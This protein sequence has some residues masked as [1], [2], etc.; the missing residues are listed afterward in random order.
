VLY[1]GM[2]LLG[3]LAS[4]ALRY[5]PQTPG[6]ETARAA[7]A[8]V[9]YLLFSAGVIA[10]IWSRIRAPRSRRW[11]TLGWRLAKLPR[12]IFE[13]IGGYGVLL[14]VL[15]VTGFGRSAILSALS[16]A[17]SG[18]G[19]V[20]NVHA[21]P[22][23]VL[24]FLLICVVA[25]VVEEM[26]FRGF[27]YAGLRRRMSVFGAVIASALLF[28]LMHNNPEALLPI[29]LIGIVLAALYE[30]NR[31]IVPSIICHALNNTLVFFLMLLAQ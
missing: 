15:A 6:A 19:L 21:T 3:M 23:K 2:A 17:Q 25:P 31:S 24:L 27:I 7:V 12:L 20:M 13:G 16:A 18:E 1:F 8:A 22:A 11:R 28:A 5:L 4:L 14:V 9:Q 26:I 10:F 29:G 30:R